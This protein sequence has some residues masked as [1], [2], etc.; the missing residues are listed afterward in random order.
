MMAFATMSGTDKPNFGPLALRLFE[1]NF[2][3]YKLCAFY[4]L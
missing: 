4:K 2:D 1:M 3:G